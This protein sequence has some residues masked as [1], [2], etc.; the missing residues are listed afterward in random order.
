MGTLKGKTAFVTGTSQGIG[1]AISK[2]LIERG[3]NIC[4]HYFHSSETPELMKELAVKK[5]LKVLCIQADLTNEQATI[6][7]I[8]E[9][10]QYFGVFDILVNNSGALVERRSVSEIDSD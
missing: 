4:M 8:K 2:E 6:R 9:A 10:V 3:C 7:C 1:A 5:G